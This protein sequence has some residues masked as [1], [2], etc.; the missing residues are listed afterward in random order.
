MATQTN[1][2]TPERYAKGLS[3]K[4]WLSKLDINADKF[5]KN[6]QE[7]QLKPEDAK[8][9]ADAAKKPNGPAKILVLAEGWC[10]DVIRGLPAVAK[11]SE[12]A[13][14]ELKI[15][16]RD[17]NLDI[18][19]QFLLKGEFQAIPAV[20]FYTKDLKYICHWLERPDSTNAEY[21][22]VRAKMGADRSKFGELT[23]PRWEHYRQESIKEM[24][25]LISKNVA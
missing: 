21:A 23:L 22:E 6:Y 1:V 19:Y 11:L 18:M 3:Y 10:P 20:I 16:F 9:F 5:D 24:K 25:E 17:Q 4:D 8:F 12:A 13:G 2:V 7:F 15:L 14:I